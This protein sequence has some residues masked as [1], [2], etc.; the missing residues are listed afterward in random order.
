MRLV[1][2]TPDYEFGAFD[3][4]DEDLNGFLIDDAKNFLSKRIAN[5]FILEEKSSPSKYAE[6][7]KCKTNICRFAFLHFSC[8][9]ALL[10]F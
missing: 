3:C 4:G 8:S 2:L 1:R 7:Q 10:R 9:F 5:T 6:V